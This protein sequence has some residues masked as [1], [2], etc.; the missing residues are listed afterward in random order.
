ML[1]SFSDLVKKMWERKFLD[2]VFQS[3]YLDLPVD[4][5]AH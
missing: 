4:I 1:L 3:K 5:V 2:L